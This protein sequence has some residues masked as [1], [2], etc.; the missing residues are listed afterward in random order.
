MTES[1]AVTCE[2]GLYRHLAPTY[3]MRHNST[4]LRRVY[5]IFNDVTTRYP[6]MTG[7]SIYIIEGYSTQGVTAVPS[8]DTA[9]P[10]REFP[11]LT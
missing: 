9:T 8:E 3:L 10:F 4:S 11:L 7:T 1:D 2:K 6:D 5:D